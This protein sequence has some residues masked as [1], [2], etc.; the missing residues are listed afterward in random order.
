MHTRASSVKY[1]PDMHLADQFSAQRLIDIVSHSIAHLCS[2][3]FGVRILITA[4]ACN[5]CVSN[6]QDNTTT[7][8]ECE[9]AN[10]NEWDSMPKMMINNWLSFVQFSRPSLLLHLPLS[11]CFLSSRCS[12]VRFPPWIEIYYF[13]G[14]TLFCLDRICSIP[15]FA[16]L[17]HVSQS[18]AF[19]GN[20][21]SNCAKW[22]ENKW[23]MHRK[24]WTRLSMGKSSTRCHDIFR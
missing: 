23:S 3:N 13:V 21:S 12:I 22:Q 14:Y 24:K 4:N 8:R 1:I 16:V 10:V 17:M 19:N 9:S 18:I 2:I 5:R 20:F 7:R 6:A 15:C 11:L